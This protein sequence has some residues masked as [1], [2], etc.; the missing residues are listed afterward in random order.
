MASASP[1]G[2]KIWH[3]L[4]WSLANVEQFDQRGRFSTTM[5]R[6]PPVIEAPGTCAVPAGGSAAAGRESI[7][8]LRPRRGHE[9]PAPGLRISSTTRQLKRSLQLAQ[10]QTSQARLRQGQL[11]PNNQARADQAGRPLASSGGR[12]QSTGRRRL[13]ASHRLPSPP[14]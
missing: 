7:K 14:H 2:S 12:P 3:T 5:R 11:R 1:A 8:A 10:A 13:V 6:F 9:A 4:A